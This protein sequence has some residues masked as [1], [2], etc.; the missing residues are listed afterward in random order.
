VAVVPNWNGRD[1]LDTVLESLAAQDFGQVGVIVVDNGS[2]DGSLEHLANHWPAVAVLENGSN[3]GFSPAVNRGIQ[4]TEGEYVALVNNDMRLEPQWVG[5]LVEAL[6]KNPNAASAACKIRMV[7]EPDLLDGAGDLVGWDGYAARRGQGEPDRGQYD[8]SEMV[9]SACAGAAMYRRSAL[10]QIGLFD[11][12]FFIY[13]CDVDWGF[14]AQL[15]GLDCVYEPHAVAHH[16]GAA[17]TGNVSGFELFL[18][19]RNMISMMV[20]DFPLLALVLN[21]PSSLARR[22]G[23]L[24]KAIKGRQARTLLR[25]WVAGMRDIPRSVAARRGIQSSR[26]RGYRELNG[27]V[28]TRAPRRRGRAP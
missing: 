20:K 27:L 11:E 14:R 3:L 1:L 19:H 21:L 18:A 17:T 12:E 25:A 2:D 6:D 7:H 10:E 16:L 9:F 24:G 4:N 13:M 26:V 8:E 23:S 22:A 15:A 28:L 5:R